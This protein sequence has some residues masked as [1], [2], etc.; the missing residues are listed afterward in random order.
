MEKAAF[1]A[2]YRAHYRRV[3]GI[4]RRLLGEAGG[5]EDAAQ[6]VFMRALKTIARYDESAPFGP[7][8]G[9]IARNHCIDQLRKRRRLASILEDA[10]AVPEAL[11]DPAEAIVDSLI[12]EHDAESIAAA[13]DAL[14]ESYRLPIVLAYYGEASYDDIAASLDVTPNH[15]GVLLLRGRR[16]LR[17]LLASAALDEQPGNQQGERQ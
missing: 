1:D 16:R 2:L 11:E 4:C 6:E 3:L 15:V 8:I 9:A 12:S 14:P 5:A 13:V 7:W 17:E 10:E